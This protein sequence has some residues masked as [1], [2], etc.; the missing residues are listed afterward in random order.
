MKILIYGAGVLGSLYAFLV[1]GG[2][3]S[4]SFAIRGTT[5]CV[6]SRRPGRHDLEQQRGATME[7]KQSLAPAVAL[8][9]FL[10][11]VVALA[12][13]TLKRRSLGS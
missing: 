2:P 10:T 3:A 7:R 11:L 8:F 13:A 5:D 6:L 4:L 1:M 9:L 12:S